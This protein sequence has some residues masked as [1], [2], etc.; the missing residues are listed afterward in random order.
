MGKY[1]YEIVWE[2]D[3]EKSYA[4]CRVAVDSKDN[5]VVCGVD[6]D[7]KGLVIKYD[8]NGDFLWDDHSFPRIFNKKFS[9]SKPINMNEILKNSIGSLLDITIDSND[10][11][12]V[13]GSFYDLSGRYCVAYVKKYSPDGKVLWEK[14]YSPFL[15]NEATGICID[16]NDDIFIAGYGGRLVPPSVKGFIMKLSKYDGRLIWKRIWRKFGKYTGYSS[17]AVNNEIVTA[18]FTVWNG[19]YDL[20][21]TKFNRFGIRKRGIE[22]KTNVF[23]GKIVVDNEGNYIVA[24]QFEDEE[25]TH[26]LLKISSA[27]S[28]LWQVSGLGGGLYDAAIMK[29]G[30][31]A[32]TGKIDEK[33]YY[34]G[35]YSKGGVK[36]LDMFLGNLVSGG[37]DM[38]DWMRGIAVDSTND[39]IIV[40]AAPIGKTIKVRIKKIEEHEEVKEKEKKEEKSFIEILM[41][42]FRKLWKR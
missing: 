36:L 2:R 14:T 27:F 5:I 7:Y 22:I 4:N 16:P 26:Y 41:D 10:N 21:I 8:K 15:Y 19:D 17:I 25:Y 38:N 33:K 1:D 20:A 3:Y 12:I 11:I 28:I 35:M 23:P 24:G 40:G 18:G 13:V 29:D 6:K 34:A 31:I 9:F 42:F 30:N 37:N 39:L 32:V